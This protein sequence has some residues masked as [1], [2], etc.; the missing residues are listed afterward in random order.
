MLTIDRPALHA[1]LAFAESR[2]GFEWANY[3]GAPDA[4]R[5]DYREAYKDLQDA[6]TLLAYIARTSISDDDLIAAA[7]NDRLQINR[8]S[9][10]SIRVDYV[11]GQYYPTEYRAAVCRVAS[12]AIWRY[13]REGSGYDTGDAIRAAARRALPRAVARRWFSQ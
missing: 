10:G 6:R 1:L 9:D 11:T 8:A 12:A 7:G 3:D 4:Y 5:A 2:P 13:F